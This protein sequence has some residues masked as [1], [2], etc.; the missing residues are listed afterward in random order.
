L[1]HNELGTLPGTCPD[2]TNT[3]LNIFGPIGTIGLLHKP[4][5]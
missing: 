4:K 3:V 2:T 1:Q 5:L